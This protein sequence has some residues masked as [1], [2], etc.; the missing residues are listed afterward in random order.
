[1]D[2]VQKHNICAVPS[3]LHIYLSNHVEHSPS[4]EGDGHL[5]SQEIPFF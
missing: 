5:A 1:M 2:K 4:W 3:V